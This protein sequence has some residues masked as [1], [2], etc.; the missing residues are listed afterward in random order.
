MLD[1]LFDQQGRFDWRWTIT[2]ALALYA[3]SIAS[4]RVYMSRRE[5]NPSIKV[6]FS[7]TMVAMLGAQTVPHIQVRVENHGRRILAFDSNCASL[8]WKGTD[9]TRL[10]IWDDKIT[11]VTTWPHRLGSGE[12]F[13]IMCKTTPLREIL[14][15]RS[16]PDTTPLRAVVVD[17]IGRQFFSDW[18]A[19]PPRATS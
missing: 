19:L 4:Y 6:I 9:G 3:A 18:V 17:A 5:R 13:Y 1:W 2:T 10:L 15:R 12:S 7:T 16:V 11:S 8:E 14:Q